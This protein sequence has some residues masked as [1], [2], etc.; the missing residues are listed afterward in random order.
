MTPRK[1]LL[2]STALVSTS[3]LAGGKLPGIVSGS[4]S[5]LQSG[6]RLTI[7]ESTPSAILN[8]Q[9]FSVAKGEIVQFVQPSASSSI[10]NRVTGSATSAIDGLVQANGQVLLLNPNGITVGTA[11][12]INA[13]SL[14]L[15]SSGLK[16]QDYLAGRL[17]FT[18]IPGQGAVTNHGTLAAA[19]GGTVVLSA[20]QVSNDGTITAHL[21]RVVMGAAAG[22]TLDPAGDGLWSYQITEAAAGALAANAGTITADGGSVQI[23]ARSLDHAM[24]DVINNTGMIE[25]RSVRQQDGEIILDGG[26]QGQVTLGSSSVIDASAGD[27]V[28]DGGHIKITGAVT[29]VD[30][31]LLARGGA[32]GGDG[33]LIETSGE[34]LKVLD[35]ARVDVGSALGHPGSWLL[36][37][38][39][40]V[41]DS[42][43]NGAIQT[44]LASGNVTVQTTSSSDTVT[45]AT[46]SNGASPGA[47]GDIDVNAALSWSANNT[48]TLDSYHSILVNTGI[49]ASGATAGLVLKTNDGGNGGVFQTGSTGSV[50]L[51]G[52]TPSLTINS[53]AYTVLS[54]AAG[55]QAMSATGFY[56]L[57]TN[58]NLS[59]IA[60]FSPIGY[61]SASSNSFPTQFAGALEG[62]GHSLTNLS[63]NDANP[64][65][66]IA[67]ISELSAGAVL[68]NFTISG[69]VIVAGGTGWNQSMVVGLDNGIIRNVGASG[70]VSIGT[71]KVNIGGLVGSTNPGATIANSYFTGTVSGAGSNT[72][73]GGLVGLTSASS[74]ISNSWAS[75]T[76]SSSSTLTNVGGLVGQQNGIVFSTYATGSLIDGA[77]AASALGGLIGNNNGGTVY[78]SYANVAVFGGSGN[79]KI[80][81]LVGSNRG[82]LSAV[83]AYGLITPG[84]TN[85][86]VGGMVG[87]VGS[88]STA[89]SAYWDITQTG[90]STS[91]LGTGVSTG[92]FLSAGPG[93]DTAFTSSSAWI[94]VGSHPYPLLTAFPYVPVTVTSSAMTYGSS[95]PTVTF[96][97]GAASDGSGAGTTGGLTYTNP[98]TATSNAGAYV[99]DLGGLVAAGYQ[100]DAVQPTFTVN[101]APLT[102]TANNASKAYGATATFASGAYTSSSLVNG[103]TLSGVTETSS[104]AGTTAAAGTYAI[105]PSAATGANGFLTSN[106]SIT[107]ANGTLTVNPAALTVTADNVAKTYG[108]SPTYSFTPTGLINSDTLSGATGTSGG[109]TVTAA[110]GMGRP[111]AALGAT[112]WRSAALPPSPKPP[113]RR[114]RTAGPSRPAPAAPIHGSSSTATHAPCCWPNTTPASPPRISCNWSLSPP[115][116]A[117]PSTATLTSASP[118]LPARCGTPPPASFPSALPPAAATPARPPSP[119]P[120]MA[121]RTASPIWR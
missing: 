95:T 41:I 102:I 46:A 82:T 60:S 45:G 115:R 80:G 119:A 43:N 120:S 39:D 87:T 52:A 30:G 1:L 98:A 25:A 113:T 89:I 117:I 10:L 19:D 20:P 107:Y 26:D 51:T 86:S 106:Y 58:V 94:F 72:N 112:I 97:L 67:F 68:S 118:P 69:T 104:G 59:S 54:T 110:V 38:T 48:L 77:G 34:S 78:N 63:I 23:S 31:V 64:D 16:D 111:A 5:F 88:G 32:Q 44:G 81:A 15:T 74:T 114:L 105:T 6:N 103:N 100:I 71:T 93:A 61:T 33:G 108:Q 65:R 35:S 29:S 85:T 53:V 47:N 7:T 12:Q 75:A 22:F 2:L 109:T 36:D 62:L 121:R 42:S 66:N 8:W 83:Y 50:N 76:V 3:A 21:G 13:A 79:S 40:F 14:L 92:S 70:T 90:Q 101:P 91:A 84:S 4:V 56:A 17:S 116:P 28:G 49:T 27:A 37:P 99:L 18:G 96:T 55:V 73:V 24:R 11:G 9:D 57:G